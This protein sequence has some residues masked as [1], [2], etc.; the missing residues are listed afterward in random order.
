[1]A[2]LIKRLNPLRLLLRLLSLI[3]R[4]LT[5]LRNRLRRHRQLEYILIT[6]PGSMPALPESRGWLRQR[7]QGAPP[8]SLWDLDRM[9]RRIAADP[10]PKGV[11]L[12]LNGLSLS[13]ADLQ[14]LRDSIA[15]L[16]ASGKRVI[17]FAQY[18]DMAQYTVASAADTIILQPGGELMTVGLRQEA[19][20]LKDALSMIGVELDVVAISPYKGV[21]DQFSRAD[22]SPEGR[23]QLQ[24]L[25]DDRF[26]QIVSAIADGRG[27]SR[28]TVQGMID[29][30]PHVDDAAL[31]AG[32]VDA[33][34]NEEDF[35][36]YLKSEHLLTW[37]DAGKKLLIQR[38]PR[39]NKYVALLT[40]SGMM[41]PGESASPPVDLPIPFVGGERAGDVT[42]V[43]QVRA[44][45]RD[46]GAAAV[47]LMIDSGG[48]AV[49]AAEAMTAALE[50]LAKT[51]PLVVYM[52]AV[53]ASG[54]YYVATPARWIVAQ[55]G[56]ITGSIGVV[57]AKPITS[58]LRNKLHVTTQTFTRGA[59][60]DIYSDTHAFSD[61]QRAQVRTSIEVVYQ[62]FIER[63][64]ASRKLDVAAVDEVG[65]GR[66]WTGAQALEHGLVDQLG[67][68]REAVAKAREFAGLPDDAPLVRFEG[69]G[70]P[71]PP[72][73]AQD[74]AALDPTRSLRYAR[75]N[76]R[77]LLNGAA[78]VITPIEWNSHV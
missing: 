76:A 65:G 45:M 72:Q 47:V 31:A 21:F 8:L 42:V 71:L 22:I 1:M 27:W 69:K 44:L 41:L 13:L 58:E 6:L 39:G 25:L 15:R 10:R 24:R 12:K 50:Q 38:E 53:A 43:Q 11:I 18:Y 23:E 29:T 40:I 68:L 7:V 55:A 51:R 74:A 62:H 20:F 37:R 14:T 54:G 59:N 77:A 35:P 33:L 56:T 49:V 63:V 34:L 78:Q 4:A 61:A 67:G 48:G 2:R 36:A 28:D 46:E 52:N 57:T 26:A 16:R 17:A 5:G 73:I 3:P 30:A 75:E 64:A 19:V 66:V 9:F 60:A 70:K 32:Y